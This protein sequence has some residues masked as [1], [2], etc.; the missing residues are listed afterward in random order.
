MKF[1]TFTQKKNFVYLKSHEKNI[2]LQRFTL[3]FINGM[4]KG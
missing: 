2:N 1:F 3:A 4:P